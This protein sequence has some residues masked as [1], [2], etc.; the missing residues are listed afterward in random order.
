MSDDP[1]AELL[2]ELERRVAARRAAGDYDLAW[3]DAEVEPM[4]PLTPVDRYLQSDPE[5]RQA[6]MRG[7]ASLVRDVDAVERQALL[8]ERLRDALAWLALAHRAEQSARE[9]L[10]AALIEET[11][12]RHA[13][14]RA[15]DALRGRTGNLERDIQALGFAIGERVYRLE[16]DRR[17]IASEAMRR[18]YAGLIDPGTAPLDLEGVEARVFSQN[19]EDGIILHLL[20]LIGVRDRRFVEIG[21]EDGRECNTANLALNFG[22]RG[23]MID[24]DP[25][26]VAAA[27]RYYAS[28][29]R[30]RDT[31]TVVERHV[32]R[33]GIDD[34]LV[35]VCGG[36]EI[37]V[38]SIDIDGNDLWVWQAVT[39]TSPRLF[40]V[41]YNASFG[42]DRSV[43]VPY[44]PDFDR[45]DKH[46]SGHYHGASLR[47]LTRVA[48]A[49]GYVLAGCDSNGVNAFFVRSDC[50]EGAIA[51]QRVEDAWRPI[52]ERGPATTEEQFS[53]I[54]H[55]PL[56]D[57]P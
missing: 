6:G 20:S 33:E 34:L 41:E 11:R 32:T 3:L 21:V 46:P 26:G 10:D 5:P 50:A 29:R 4:D 45:M 44:D 52:R 43:S 12:G 16:D 15:L 24:R 42:P 30:T 38:L 23:V 17:W 14:E 37:D 57:V 53:A 9:A 39:R 19:G 28:R 49:K 51:P 13:V 56:E 36:G 31:V 35:E 54:A 40:V 1:N 7:L 18:G 47:A 8:D 22:W 2:A 27:R 55:L 25:G 48:D